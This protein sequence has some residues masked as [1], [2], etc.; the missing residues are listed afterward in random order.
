LRLHDSDQGRPGRAM[1]HAGLDHR[2]G[3]VRSPNLFFGL[4]GPT[5]TIGGLANN[6]DSINREFFSESEIFPI[7]AW[8]SGGSLEVKFACNCNVDC[9]LTDHLL[10]AT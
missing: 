1:A 9:I 8:F 5:E 4:S 10:S 6:A 2:L 3:L 7:T